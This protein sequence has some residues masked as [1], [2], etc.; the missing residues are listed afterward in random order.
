MTV[1]TREF[2]TEMKQLMDIIIHSLY[3]NREI[4][5][6][7]LISNASDAIDKA[8][9]TAITEPDLLEGNSEWQIRLIPNAEAGT[10]T[11]SDNGIGMSRESII[12]DLGTIARSGTGE[13]LKKLAQAE[14]QDKP[15]MIGQFGVGFYSA[16]MVAEKVEVTSRMA[17]EKTAGVRWISDGQGAYSVEEV[18]KETR[19]TEIVLH[20]RED[21]KDFLNEWTLRSIV[22][23][24]SDFIEHPVVMRV[25]RKEGEETVGKDETLNQ[26]QAIWLR[27]KSEI[28][29]EEYNAFYKHIS[30]DTEDP[31]EVIHFVAEGT[32]EFKAL[33][34]IPKN[35]PFDFLLPDRK[36]GLHLY[37]KRVFITDDSEDLL[38]PYLR[39]V[40][41]VVD[42][43][44]LP[45]NVSREMLQQNPVLTKIR[46]NLID[47]VLGVLATMQKK[48]AEKYAQFFKTF[49]TVL[50]EGV[51]TDWSN[52][53]K[54]ADLLQYEATS[55][56]EGETI[57]LAKYVEAM[58]E[59]QKEIYYLIGETRSA[60]ERSPYLEAF[61]TRKWDVLLM[62][63]PMDEWVIQ[64]L[65]EYKEKKLKAVDKGELDEQLSAED[66]P[67]ENR[68]KQQNE[69]K[70]LLAML[71][72]KLEDIK[73]VRLSRRL[74][75]SASCLVVEEGEMGA[76]VQNLLNKI[77]PENQ[78]T[79][80]QRY[81]E[82][83][84]KHAVV[85]TMQ[86][87]YAENKDDERV[88]DYA[89]LLLDQAVLAEGSKIKD[90]SA[91]ARRINELIVK[92]HG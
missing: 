27:S 92:L 6:R 61:R 57:S 12:E 15:D 52:R 67:E 84:P 69:Y 88:L 91:L 18:E 66:E 81:L 72:D 48:E 44:D 40:R 89:Q 53:E 50:K 33:L 85:T 70:D 49:G 73:E 1:E 79:K 3:S 37:I 29:P 25:E 76:Y 82:L 45:L 31:A 43:A 68:E 28:K 59:D 41:G 71:G 75:E 17:G 77:D 4:F 22:S 26:R 21:A 16:F 80:T 56:K 47:K 35:K 55:T 65:M 42:A 19:G 78:Q 38:P 11:V 36:R 87:L 9:F 24:F 46:N 10:L 20:L 14:N 5:L 74:T 86:K 2:K 62:T 90:P 64:G 13:F 8:R 34:F 23:K 58:P 30:R 39:F 54:L 51:H 32:L 83:N 60:L 63:D 7:E